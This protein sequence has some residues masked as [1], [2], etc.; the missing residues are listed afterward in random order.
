MEF[1]VLQLRFYE[2]PAHIDKF[3][4]TASVKRIIYNAVLTIKHFSSDKALSVR[5]FKLLFAKEIFEIKRNT[6]VFMTKTSMTK[7]R[8]KR[9]YNE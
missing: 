8:V 4:I 7:Y 9:V 2:G 5:L 3:K 1:Y 6:I